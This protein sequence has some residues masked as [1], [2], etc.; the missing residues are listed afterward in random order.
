M[1]LVLHEYLKHGSFSTAKINKRI[2]EF[3]YRKPLKDNFVKCRNSGRKLHQR[4]NRT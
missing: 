4:G 1:G 2:K 3:V